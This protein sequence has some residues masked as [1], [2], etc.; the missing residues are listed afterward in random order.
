MLH[1]SLYDVLLVKQDA[2]LDE[3]K[4][5]FKKRALQV[6]PDKGGSKEA[7]HVVYQA[8]ETLVDPAARQKYDTSLALSRG[9]AQHW[10]GETKGKKK[11]ARK[12]WAAAANQKRSSAGK[13]TTSRRRETDAKSSHSR[14]NRLLMKVRDLLE[15]LP[16]DLR[17][18]VFTKDSPRNSA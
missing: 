15:Q 13:G 16:R 12:R 6:H 9:V 3:I 18:E 8:L 4:L 5:A 2:T 14:Q 7:F 10:N 1:E 11:T 17:S